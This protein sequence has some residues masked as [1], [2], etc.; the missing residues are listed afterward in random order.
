M[1]ICM[2]FMRSVEL[3]AVILR[4]SSRTFPTNV[5]TPRT[6]TFTYAH[7]I[8]PPSAFSDIPFQTI[9]RLGFRGLIID[10]D[11]TLTVPYER[12]LR[13]EYQVITSSLSS[14][15]IFLQSSM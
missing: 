9:K 8:F 5:I 15:P 11:N 2:E 1:S 13:P 3:F 14:L 12:T 10:K 4:C 7:F 6:C